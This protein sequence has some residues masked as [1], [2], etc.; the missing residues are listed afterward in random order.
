MQNSDFLL[1]LWEWVE[2]FARFF[3]DDGN[4]N[5]CSLQQNS[6]KSAKIQFFLQTNFTGKNFHSKFTDSTKNKIMFLFS[7]DTDQFF[8]KWEF[9][10]AI[11]GKNSK[12]NS[13]LKKFSGGKKMMQKI[14]FQ[15]SRFFV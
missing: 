3:N 4:K 8:S 12:K 11:F 10:Y 9:F 13:V 14:V 1:I 7:T 2:I 15:K 5:A 6:K